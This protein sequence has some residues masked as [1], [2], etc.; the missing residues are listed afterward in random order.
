L[1]PA[2][3]GDRRVEEA[4]MAKERSRI[5]VKELKMVRADE[6]VP[7]E[8]NFRRHTEHQRAALQGILDEVGF[9]GAVLARQRPDGKY[10]IIDGHMR[11]EEAAP[12]EELPVLV[13]D[14]TDEEADKVLATHD[15]I[16]GLAEI[17]VPALEDLAAEIAFDHEDLNSLLN[18][19][20]AM[21]Y[22][23]EPPDE[24]PEHDESDVDKVVYVTCPECGHEFPK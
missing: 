12:D 24:W 17:D 15:A 3:G 11:Q 9:A 18:S 5:R 10:E 20:T 4:T 1:N 21:G 6:L 2:A 19:I 22:N 14:L 23:P 8:K 13:T 16:G 7:S